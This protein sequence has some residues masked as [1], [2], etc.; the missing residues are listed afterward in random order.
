M[1]GLL[2]LR[3][4]RVERAVRMAEAEIA[5]CGSGSPSS[6]PAGVGAADLPMPGSAERSTTWTLRRAG[7]DPNGSA[8]SR[9]SSCRANELIIST[10]AAWRL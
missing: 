6:M 1:R 9:F 4:E 5:Q 8:A 3:N 2:D 7:P 10:D